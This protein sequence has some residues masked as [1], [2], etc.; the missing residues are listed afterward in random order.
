MKAVCKVKGEKFKK[1]ENPGYPRWNGKFMNM[2][3]VLYL[4]DV[5]QTLFIEDIWGPYIFRGSDWKL[6][7]GAVAIV[8]PF[9]IATKTLGCYSDQL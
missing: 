3:S 1:L 8:K 2:E 9:L 7:Q 6:F 4:K 5:L